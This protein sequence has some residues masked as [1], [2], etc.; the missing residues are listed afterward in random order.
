MSHRSLHL[1]TRIFDTPLAIEPSKLDMILT[2]LAPRLTIGADSIPLLAP[3]EEQDDL[4]AKSYLVTDDG[5]ACISIQGT[6]VNKSYGMR[7]LSGLT[8]YSEIRECVEDAM[9]DSR[10]QA[11]LFDVDSPGGE[12]SGCPDLANF[13]F[14]MRGKKPMM[15]IANDACFSAAY[16]LASAAGK[17]CITRTGGVGSIGVVAVHVDQ[18]KFDEKLGL[19]YDFLHYGA[20]KVDGNPHLVLSDEARANMQAEIDRC[21]EMFVAAV[22][23]N[24]GVDL[25]TVRDTEAQ[26]YFGEKALGLLADMVGTC[27]DALN[28]LRGQIAAQGGERAG[29]SIPATRGESSVPW[30]CTPRP[31]SRSALSSGNSPRDCPPS[32]GR[33]RSRTRHHCRR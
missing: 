5:I 17:L 27:E 1:A 28:Y 15:A 29:V 7:A 20:R 33:G 16:W 30:K 32:R 11:L 31:A 3:D 6:L 8:T 2:V 12:V 18:T 23:R 24:R 19:S 26:C 22:A 21:G 25:Q 10:I 4:A 13:I 14:S 9:Q